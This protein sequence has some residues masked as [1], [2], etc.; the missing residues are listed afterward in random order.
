[1]KNQVEIASVWVQAIGAILAAL[2][3][4]AWNL[5]SEEEI[6]DLDLI[7]NFLQTLEMPYRQI[8]KKR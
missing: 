2:G 8:N 5:L 7:G 6:K 3:N 4:S 1:M